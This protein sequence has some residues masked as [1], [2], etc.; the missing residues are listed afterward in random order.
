M[1]EVKLTCTVGQ[2]QTQASTARGPSKPRDSEPKPAT[3]SRGNFKKP[4]KFSGT[5]KGKGP[6]RTK[7]KQAAGSRNSSNNSLNFGASRKGVQ[8]GGIGMMPI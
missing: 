8:S 2:V 6:A 4:R 5:S 7:K 3:K 1:G